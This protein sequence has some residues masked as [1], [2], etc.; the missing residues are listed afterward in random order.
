MAAS[1][2]AGCGKQHAMSAPFAIDALSLKYIN[3][4][5]CTA[6]NGYANKKV[7]G[8]YNAEATIFGK[9]LRQLQCMPEYIEQSAARPSPR[10]LW[11]MAADKGGERL[12]MPIVLSIPLNTVHGRGLR[13]THILQMPCTSAIA[14][15]YP[16]W[17]ILAQLC[18]CS[19]HVSGLKTLGLLHQADSLKASYTA[20]NPQLCRCNLSPRPLSRS[21]LLT[22]VP[23]VH[24]CVDRT[25]PGRS[26][27]AGKLASDRRAPVWTGA[28]L[29]VV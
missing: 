29:T 22:P 1:A 18:S 16:P 11:S 9:C 2:I 6:G 24:A 3:R 23:P 7:C 4:N 10:E 17:R 19:L 28:C 12:P 8:N 14:Q 26:A 25:S 5:A 20:G 15:P 13:R 27:S 21:P